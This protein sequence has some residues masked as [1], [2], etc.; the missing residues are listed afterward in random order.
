VEDVDSSVLCE[1]SGKLATETIV[2]PLVALVDDFGFE[3]ANHTARED[4]AGGIG[5]RRPLFV[6]DEPHVGTGGL[7]EYRTFKL[8]IRTY[9]ANS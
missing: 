7:E 1:H 3:R 5:I 6:L 4:V 2:P 8:R 9:C